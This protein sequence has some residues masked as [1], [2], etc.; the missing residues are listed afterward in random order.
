MK[1]FRLF[2][3]LAVLAASAI[4]GWANPAPG[5]YSGTVLVTKH[6]PVEGITRLTSKY[7]MKAQAHVAADGIVTILTT[8]P[9]TPAAAVDIE[10]T[11]TRATPTPVQITV[12]PAPANNYVVDG[13]YPAFVTYANDVLKLRYEAGRDITSGVVDLRTP[14]TSFNF[15]FRKKRQ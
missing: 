13:N 6:L 1:T 7:S 3:G 10:S 11:V 9:Q 5:V 4:E 15:T 2:I 14:Y 8:T 12:H